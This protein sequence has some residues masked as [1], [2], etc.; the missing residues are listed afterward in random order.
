LATSGTNNVLTAR[1]AFIV[2]AVSAGRR[3]EIRL[4]E[5]S[6]EGKRRNSY[7]STEI[8]ISG[9]FGMKSKSPEKQLAGFLAKYTLEISALAKKIFGKMRKRLPGAVE[10]VYDN[11]NA[12][13]IGFG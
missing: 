9:I 10:L 4:A 12:L 6:K 2:V 11:Y 5:F 7:T 8:A 1:S 3:D 13:V